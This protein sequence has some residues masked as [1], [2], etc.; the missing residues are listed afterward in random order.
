M[1][2]K[3]RKA[4]L[5]PN[6]YKMLLLNRK[7]HART[8]SDSTS[9]AYPS[10]RLRNAPIRHETTLKVWPAQTTT[11]RGLLCPVRARPGPLHGQR[12]MLLLL[13][14]VGFLPTEK[15]H[16]LPATI[17]TT[18]FTAVTITARYL[19]GWFTVFLF[20]FFPLGELNHLAYTH[21]LSHGSVHTSGL[22]APPLFNNYG[23]TSHSWNDPVAQHSGYPPIIEQPVSGVHHDMTYSTA[24]PHESSYS[25]ADY[26]HMGYNAQGVHQDVYSSGAVPPFSHHNQ[27]M[28]TDTGSEDKECSSNEG[29]YMKEH[30][31][32]RDVYSPIAVWPSPRNET[33][34]RDQG[35]L[36]GAPRVLLSDLK[37]PTSSDMTRD[38]RDNSSQAAK[39]YGSIS[40][41]KHS[42]IVKK[43]SYTTT[44]KDVPFTDSGYGSISNPI[45]LADVNT[46]GPMATIREADVDAQTLYSDATTMAHMDVQQYISDLSDDIYGKLRFQISST[47]WSILAKTLPELMKAFAI[48][49]GYGSPVQAN[50][51]IMYFIHRRHR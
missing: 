2:L 26:A 8:D 9:G 34:P 22:A 44:A 30:P 21:S 19:E 18:L 39:E 46:E 49:I 33:S 31:R 24:P 12:L 27:Q 3:H 1:A 4:D 40:D 36:H 38:H 17:E 20:F 37:S 7:G 10:L 29:L 16:G 43:E 6:R 45:Q 5:A 14:W 48:K 51:D 11:P 41:T 50:R 13:Q 15:L 28:Y 32:I 23:N 35:V 42:D 47:D 25:F